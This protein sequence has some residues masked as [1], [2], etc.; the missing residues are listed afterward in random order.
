MEFMVFFFFSSRRRHTRLVS[1]W[2]SDVCSSD[3]IQ[4]GDL[5]LSCYGSGDFRA[6][7]VSRISNNHANRTLVRLRTAAGRELLSTPEHIHFAD[8]VLG[9]S[10]QRFYTYLMW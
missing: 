3:L 1:D 4:P 9:D 2:S 6:A 10:P 7:R 8:V 5:V